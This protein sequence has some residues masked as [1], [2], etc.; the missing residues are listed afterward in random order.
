MTDKLTSVFARIRS[1]NQSCASFIH[2]TRLKRRSVFSCIVFTTTFLLAAPI[3]VGY[4][5][6]KN[7]NDECVIIMMVADF[8]VASFNYC[9]RQTAALSLLS[10]NKTHYI[11]LHDVYI[12]EFM[13]TFI[14]LNSYTNVS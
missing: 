11:K 12:D 13:F 6:H 14:R 7:K 2:Y 4:Q 8:L 9:H 10:H 3:I 5:G 1:V